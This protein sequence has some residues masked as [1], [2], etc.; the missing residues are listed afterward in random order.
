MAW[1]WCQWHRPMWERH[2][3]L[4]QIPAGLPTEGIALR[5]ARISYET[6]SA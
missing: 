6:C 1:Y 2:R 4:S 3:A 5:S